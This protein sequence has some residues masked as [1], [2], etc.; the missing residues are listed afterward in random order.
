ML[1]IVLGSE[2]KELKSKV[3]LVSHIDCGPSGSQQ[4]ANIFQAFAE[5]NV[6]GIWR[7]RMFL[8]RGL[9][10]ASER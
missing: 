1:G 8:S 5:Q 10:F 2:V 4:T 9:F 3:E 6:M 7:N